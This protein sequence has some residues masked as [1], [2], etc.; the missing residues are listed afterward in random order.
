MGTKVKPTL[1][2]SFA[3]PAARSQVVDDRARL[4][5]GRDRRATVGKLRY[6]PVIDVRRLCSLAPINLAR[7]LVGSSPDLLWYA[8]PTAVFGCWGPQYW[9]YSSSLASLFTCNQPTVLVANQHPWSA[10]G[11][12]LKPRRSGAFLWVST[13]VSSSVASFPEK[14]PAHNEGYHGDD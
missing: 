13:T 12:R 3:S 4:S 5:V 11:V 9:E 1:S 14:R 7:I 2:W 6:D 8:K 10:L